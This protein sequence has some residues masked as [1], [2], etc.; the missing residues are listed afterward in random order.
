LDTAQEA[1]DRVGILHRGKLVALNTVDELLDQRNTG[2]LEEVFLQ[3]TA[4]RA[5]GKSARNARQ[6]G[7]LAPEKS[8]EE[9]V[10]TMRNRVFK[11]PLSRRRWPDLGYDRDRRFDERP[12]HS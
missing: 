9:G 3:I 5:F 8:G 6:L 2:D 1:C 12:H 7:A 10:D 4:E 11:R